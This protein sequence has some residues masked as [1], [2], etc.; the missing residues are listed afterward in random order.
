MLRPGN[1]VGY[2][3]V[4]G[5]RRF[6]AYLQQAAQ[7]YVLTYAGLAS[8]MIALVFLY[9]IACIFIFGGEFPG[10]SIIPRLYTIHVLL[11]PGLLLAAAIATIA[12]I[13]VATSG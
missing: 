9:T 8:V 13:D 10:E 1:V 4:A 6:G 5:R 11:I 7:N 2:E 3:P 12:S